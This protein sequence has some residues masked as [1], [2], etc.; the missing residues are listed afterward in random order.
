[1][2]NSTLETICDLS[3]DYN[4]TFRKCYDLYF[5]ILDKPYGKDEKHNVQLLTRYVKSK[6]N[7]RQFYWR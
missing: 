6:Y 1:M 4:I 3:N 5:R 2:K 7:I